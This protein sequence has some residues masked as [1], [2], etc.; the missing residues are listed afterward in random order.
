MRLCSCWQTCKWV[1]HYWGLGNFQLGSL[2]LNVLIWKTFSVTAVCKKFSTNIG[3]LFE[4]NKVFVI[5]VSALSPRSWDSGCPQPRSHNVGGSYWW[6]WEL[7]FT[8][9]PSYLIQR[10]YWKPF[11]EKNTWA[12]YRN[13]KFRIKSNSWHNHKGDIRWPVSTSTHIFTTMQPA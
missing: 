12:E 3:S 7:F 6:E 9:R 13:T 11:C 4:W 10:C 8:F 2:I 1:E 5:C